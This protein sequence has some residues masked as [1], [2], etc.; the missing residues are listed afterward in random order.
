MTSNYEPS[1]LYPEGLHRDRVLPAIELIQAR[2]D[3]MNVDAG[4][5]YRRRSLEQVQCYH[6]PLDERAGGAARSVQSAGRHAAAGT[7]VAYRA[8]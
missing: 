1:T 6:T 5:D 8:P 4:V 2:M 3:V 7:V